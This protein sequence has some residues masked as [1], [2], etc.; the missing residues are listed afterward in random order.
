MTEAHH[1]I[2]VAVI[3]AGV[4]GSAVAWD[5]STVYDGLD[6]FVFERNPGVTE[7]ENQSTRNSGVI[8]SGLYYD[9]E[10]RPNKARLCVKG[11]EYLYYFCSRYHVP[12]IKTGKIIVATNEEEDSVLGTYL[13]RA[14]EN[15]VRGV[16]YLTRSEIRAMEPNVR[17]KSG[18]FV[19]SAGIVDP[20]T[21]VYRLYT[22]A[23]NHGVEFLTNTTVLDLKSDNGRVVLTIEYR[24]GTT[25]DISARLIINAAGIDAD[26]LAKK[27]NPDLGLELD[28]VRGES[29]KFYAHKRPELR[30]TG[31]NI[32]PTPERVESRFANHFT[33][34]IHLT[35]TFDDLNYPGRLGDTILVGPKLVPVPDRDN[36]M[37]GVTPAKVFYQKVVTY[38]PG[39]REKD[40]VFHQMGLQARL[41]GDQDFVL[42]PDLDNGPA[43]HLLGIDSP[44]LT[45]CLA[46]AREVTSIVKK[47]H[48]I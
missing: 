29:Y 37:Q 44:G 17:A 42:L 16:R 32:Y 22:L 47:N 36:W 28:P 20:P 35:P 4:V 11:N 12:A 19:P 15:G 14:E 23:G 34:G 18:L 30:L 1:N 46:I 6:I 7:G 40:L 33:V 45:S 21:L 10:T 5:L 39:L 2:D 48:L 25:Q 24:D 9:M 13:N 43:I 27:L 26:R 8:H 41:K 31:M 38:F 3:G